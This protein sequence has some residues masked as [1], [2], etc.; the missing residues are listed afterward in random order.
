MQYGVERTNKYSREESHLS[1]EKANMDGA[2]DVSSAGLCLPMS[3][4]KCS[5]SLHTNTYHSIRAETC[6]SPQLLTIH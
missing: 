6:A 5:K 4:Q 3:L 1:D 2:L